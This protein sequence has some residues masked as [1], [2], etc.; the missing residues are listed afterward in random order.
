MPRAQKADAP[1][2]DGPSVLERAKAHFSAQD[3]KVIEVPEWGEGDEPL[4]IYATPLTLAEK[5]KIFRRT[6][7]K[8]I[9]GLI[10]VLILKACNGQGEPLFNLAD[11]LDLLNRVDPDVLSRVALEIMGGQLD[12]D[13]ETAEALDRD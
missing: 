1:V 5:E 12:Q 10:H 3:V 2:E 13:I 9:E 6:R 7:D 8:Q 11:K 4:R